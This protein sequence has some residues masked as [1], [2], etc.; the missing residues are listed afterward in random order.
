MAPTHEQPKYVPTEEQIAADCAEIK[1]GWTDIQRRSRQVGPHDE[2]VE[3]P[4]VEFAPR[5][6]RVMRKELTKR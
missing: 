2:D 3:L 4:Y 1:S 5:G 6:R